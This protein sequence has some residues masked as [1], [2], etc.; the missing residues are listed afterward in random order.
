MTEVAQH[1][2]LLIDEGNDP[3]HDPAPLREYMDG[4]DG[5]TFLRAL[6]LDGTQ[7]V[8][9]IGVGTGRLALRTA[10]HCRSFTGID[11]SEKTIHR[12]GEN[13]AHLHN[14][15]LI[16]ADFMTWQPVQKY[17][18]VYSSLTFMHFAD[19]QRAAEKVAACLKE[20]G[21]A[22]LSLDK[23]DSHVIDYGTRQITVYPDDPAAL[24]GHLCKA[25]MKVLPTQ[26][27]EF[28]YI[29]TAVREGAEAS[30]ASS[31]AD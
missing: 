20:G 22:V 29:L 15:H 10:E 8:L 1:Y 7:D 5:E 25:G 17:D 3:V 6:A 19:K 27:T 14:V 16:W 11:L 31:S 24:A 18:V 28:A 2:D 26:E 9:E 4:W 30:W 12:A 21:R 23:D 13:L